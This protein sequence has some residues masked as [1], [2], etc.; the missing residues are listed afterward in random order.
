MISRWAGHRKVLCPVVFLEPGQGA[1]RAAEGCREGMAGT[2]K[3]VGLFA[4]LAA[5]SSQ[6]V[7]DSSLGLPD[8]SLPMPD[9][10]HSWVL[11]LLGG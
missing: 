3:G 9:S 4:P 5:D 6:P 7:A 8:S 11:W 10:S 1:Q 2:G